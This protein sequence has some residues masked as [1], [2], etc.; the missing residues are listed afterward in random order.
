L[1]VQNRALAVR[2]LT[3][4][5]KKLEDIEMEHRNTFNLNPA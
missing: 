2:V 3:R 5:K 4:T 1:I